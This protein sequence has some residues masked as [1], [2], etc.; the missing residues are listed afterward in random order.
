MLSFAS[1]TQQNTWYQLSYFLHTPLKYWLKGQ[2]KFCGF[3]T[4]R[5]EYC[6]L[7]INI[8][9]YKTTTAETALLTWDT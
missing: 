7:H 6:F 5:R 4:Y 1:D 2:K 3:A 9:F 8:T